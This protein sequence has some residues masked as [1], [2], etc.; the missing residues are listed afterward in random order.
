MV[1]VFVAVAAGG[2]LIWR[3][4]GAV[5]LA[6]WALLAANLADIPVSALQP[7][8]GRTAA[9]LVVTAGALAL[10]V[11][12]LGAVLIPAAAQMVR[13]P[14]FLEGAARTV[15]RLAQS[16]G[17][18]G[19]DIME[20]IP[21]WGARLVS[22]TAGACAA[23]GTGLAKLAAVCALTVFDLLDWPRLSLRAALFVPARWRARAIGALR[24]V[25]RDLGAYLRG[26]LT[27][28]ASVSAL[29]VM[30]LLAAQAPLPLA[31]GV[32]YGV[33]NAIPYIGPL[34]ATI[35]PV[36]AALALGWRSAIMTLILLLI[37]QQIDNY[38]I[39]P[40]VLGAASGL[41]PAAVLLAIAVGSALAGVAG[42]F[43]ALPV[44]VAARSVYRVFFCRV[45]ADEL[46][47]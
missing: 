10:V 9:A 15:R 40:R 20:M 13:L 11:G 43:L 4:F 19:L 47:A 42:M 37:I 1:A 44:T 6:L 24:A 23:L 7:R 29:T 25:R 12:V 30:A 34:V 33:L 32:M 46:A 5:K 41:G 16:N 28:M 3:A 35:P 45:E 38:V 14:V 31:M 36:L 21:T 8:L 18:G 22:G 17:L 39:S 26:Q 27:V 2:W